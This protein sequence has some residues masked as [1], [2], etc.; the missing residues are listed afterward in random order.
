MATTSRSSSR[1]NT[2]A[3]NEILTMLVEDHKRAKKAFR[4]FEQLDAED[5]EAECRELVAKTCA[6]LTVHATVEEELLYPAAREALSEEDLIDEAEVEHAGARDLIEQ[7]KNMEPGDDK[8]A[9]K[10]T[11][12]GE[13][14]K[15]HIKEEEGEM[16]PQVSSAKLD[17]E[18]LAAQ[19]NARRAELMQ[20]LGLDG[21]EAQSPQPAAGAQASEDDASDD[22]DAE[23][24]RASRAKNSRSRGG[25]RADEDQR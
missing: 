1:A 9:A 2:N 24:G 5:D 7:L 3:R 6:E 16:F 13:Y 10:F 20:S 18:S 12:L 4:R 25:V 8:Y 15:H 21:G 19:M 14:I 11:V 23:T 22:T 17:W